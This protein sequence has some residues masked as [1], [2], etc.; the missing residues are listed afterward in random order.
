L[1]VMVADKVVFWEPAAKCDI[2]VF[3]TI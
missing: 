2:Y 3:P 1:I